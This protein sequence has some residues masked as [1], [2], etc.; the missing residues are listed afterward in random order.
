MP[1]PPE[2][3]ETAISR[4]ETRCLPTVPEDVRVEVAT[5]QTAAGSAAIDEESDVRDE[6]S[7]VEAVSTVALVLALMFVAS[8]VDAA[9]TI[10][11]VFPFTTEVTDD[12]AD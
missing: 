5:F 3:A 11:F 10:A 4:L 1:A 2:I 8:D 6:P 7:D 12:D 9:N